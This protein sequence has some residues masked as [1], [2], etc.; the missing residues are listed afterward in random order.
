MTPHA[1]VLILI[2]AACTFFW[3]VLPF[4]AFGGNR[5]LPPVIRR[6]CSALPPAIIAVLLV[7]CL[8]SASGGD[9]QGIAAAVV[10]AAA[11]KLSHCAPLSLVV[12]T[13]AYMIII[14][15]V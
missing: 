13:A 5:P 1:F 4:A 14:R 11:Y 12:G 10:T 7:Y 2:A 15:M 9:W 6:L 8:R 3:R